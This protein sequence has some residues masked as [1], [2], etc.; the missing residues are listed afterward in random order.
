[1]KNKFKVG[2]FIKRKGAEELGPVLVVVKSKKE[3][4]FYYATTGGV[5]QFSFYKDEI[6]ES[7]DIIGKP[8]VED[9]HVCWHEQN[10][11]TRG[12]SD[13]ENSISIIERIIKAEI[14]L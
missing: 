1:M 12:K 11:V 7:Y 9:E 2:D 10:E 13:K 4:V 5:N 3:N 8:I 6:K 14:G